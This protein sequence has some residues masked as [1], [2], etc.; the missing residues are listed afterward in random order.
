MAALTRQCP[1][2]TAVSKGISLCVTV[3][4]YQRR[5]S[6]SV[7]AHGVGNP[8]DLR[9]LVQE[10]L[11]SRA[12]QSA[13]QRTIQKRLDFVHG[14]RCESQQC[15]HCGIRLIMPGTTVW[16][17]TGTLWS[18]LIGVN[19]DAIPLK[20]KVKDGGESKPMGG[21][22]HPHPGQGTHQSVHVPALAQPL[23]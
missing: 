22:P 1:A 20:P 21:A 2:H 14:Y 23:S 11:E 4:T 16:W 7:R 18:Y 8:H 13:S 15:V 6:S 17:G 12:S 5:S 19:S 9:W 3:P 10:A